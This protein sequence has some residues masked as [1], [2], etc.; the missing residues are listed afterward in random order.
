MK[1]TLTALGLLALALAGCGSASSTTASAPGTKG[2]SVGTTAI[3]APT[4]TKAAVTTTSASAVKDDLR[5]AIT[6]EGGAF[7][8][9]GFAACVQSNN[10]CGPNQ[11]GFI[12]GAAC[13]ASDDLQL[14]VTNQAGTVL[15]SED[16]TPGDD[17]G[18]MSNADGGCD[19]NLKI[20]TVPTAT[21]YGFVI[22]DQSESQSTQPTY[23]SLSQMK[24]DG[25]DIGLSYDTSGG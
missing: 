8:T 12:D 24:S 11:N 22:T 23:Y 14:T 18:R 19:V 10:G 5:V 15:A 17:G 25:Y 4:T 2:A 3:K 13:N 7:D 20:G 6:L 21:E 16:M 9:N 1:R